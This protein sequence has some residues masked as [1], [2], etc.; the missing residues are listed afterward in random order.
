MYD[1]GE[2]SEILH[3]THRMHSCFPGRKEKAIMSCIT[4]VSKPR[5]TRLFCVAIGHIYRGADKFLAR[6]DWKK[7]LKGR[8]FWSDAEV[9]AAAE[10]WLGGQP[11]ELFLS[12]LQKLVW[13]L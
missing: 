8:H 9:I 4:G 6:P 1:E 2:H 12:G 10:T 3:S 7:Q 5:P 13:S 11:S